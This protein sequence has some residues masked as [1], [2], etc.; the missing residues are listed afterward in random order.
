MGGDDGDASG[1]LVVHLVRDPRAVIHSQIKTFNVAHKYRHYFNNRPAEGNGVEK[2]T[3]A[4]ANNAT[5]GSAGAGGGLTSLP[6][7]GAERAHAL[8]LM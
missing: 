7:G 6:W 3:P 1:L 5:E 8:G 4:D 2:K